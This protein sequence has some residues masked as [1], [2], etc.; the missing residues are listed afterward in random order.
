MKLLRKRLYRKQIKEEDLWSR[1]HTVLTS[2]TRK[3]PLQ[4][5]Q[6]WLVWQSII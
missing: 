4:V 3:V 6:N 5:K 1:V 2:V